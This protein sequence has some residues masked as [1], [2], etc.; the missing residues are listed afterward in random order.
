M[1]EQW[2]E[3]GVHITHAGEAVAHWTGYFHIPGHRTRSC[4]HRHA[5]ELSASRCVRALANRAERET[6]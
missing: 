2:V 4:N 6:R 1:T 3:S 5:S